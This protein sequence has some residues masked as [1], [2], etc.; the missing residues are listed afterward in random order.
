MQMA[1]IEFARHVAG[2]SD[3]HSAEFDSATA[4]PVIDLMPDQVGVTAK[5]GTM[6]LGE[7]PCL[8]TAGT[9]AQ[10][11]YGAERDLGAPPPPLRVQ[12][13]VTAR[14]WRRR[15]C[16]SAGTSPDGRLVEMVELPEHPWYVGV[17]V[18]PGVQEPPR[19]PPPP[20]PRLRHRRIGAIAI[21]KR[22]APTGAALS[23]AD[24]P[25]RGGR[26]C[27]PWMTAAPRRAGPMCPAVLSAARCH[28]APVTVS[29]AR[30]SVSLG[31]G[32]RIAASLRSSQ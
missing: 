19:P 25:R 4:H 14:R 9:R 18:P 11:A 23:H 10:A 6:R 30:E 7:Y 12:Q 8:L 2:W 5:G 28:S 29:L 3:A 16:A 21:K 17:P 15:G 22:A 32:E 31:W 20:V 27:P 24:S 26:L 13:R 1:V